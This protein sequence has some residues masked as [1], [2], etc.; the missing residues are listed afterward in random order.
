[1]E[2]FHGDLQRL[3]IRTIDF[4]TSSETMHTH[5]RLVHEQVPGGYGLG[6]SDV[7]FVI[8]A[9]LDSDFISAEEGLLLYL[10]YC[11]KNRQLKG[12]GF[13]VVYRFLSSEV[14]SKVRFQEVIPYL[15][16]ALLEDGLIGC[17]L[18][19][20]QAV[21]GESNSRQLQ[22]T[23]ISCA[24][25]WVVLEEQLKELKFRTLF[26]SL[27]GGGHLSLGMYAELLET[28]DRLNPGL[29]AC[30]V[31]MKMMACSPPVLLLLGEPES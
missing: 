23:L 17:G 22:C 26:A 28:V 18:H 5:T 16:A 19:D 7:C 6:R 2:E 27:F 21:L 31:G 10:D 9:P 8:D 25:P 1:M 11:Q 12:E 20:F 15:R 4:C 14:P 3:A 29:A 24:E 13:Q 30:C